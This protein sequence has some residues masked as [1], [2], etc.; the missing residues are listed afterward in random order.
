MRI[1]QKEGS[2]G[3]LKFIQRLVSGR[4]ALLD[5]RLRE[6][7][8]I[9]P[10]VEVRW[11]SPR[12]DDDWAE[13]RDSAFLER[14][15]RGDLVADLRAFWPSRGPQWDALGIAGDAVLLVEAKA[16]VGE[17][18]STCTAKSPR[19][20]SMIAK[21][22]YETKTAL[23]AGADCNWLSGY[24]QLANRLAHLEFLRR[25]GV[26][27][28]LVLLQFTGDTGMPTPSTRKAYRAA[29]DVALAHLGFEPSATIPDVVHIYV[30]VAELE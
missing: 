29:L 17:L 14:V 22:F 24:Y 8:A 15:G 20:R 6:A 1:P 18:V 28:R 16:H 12:V 30:D 10:G 13:Y 26:D 2:R 4:P 19:S 5:A 11:V 21:A 9:P 7:G 3:S 25:R 27:A 23:G